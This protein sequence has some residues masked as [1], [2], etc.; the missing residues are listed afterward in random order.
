M[1]RDTTREDIL[2]APS[3]TKSRTYA[4]EVHRASSSVSTTH[5]AVCSS[6]S[7]LAASSSWARSDGDPRSKS[8]TLVL[9]LSRRERCSSY[10]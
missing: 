4:A 2:S 6:P 7:H 9:G 3:S 8:Q 5:H 1:D 10:F